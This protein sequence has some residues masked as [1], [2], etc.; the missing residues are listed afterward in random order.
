MNETDI[1]PFKKLSKCVK[2]TTTKYYQIYSTFYVKKKRTGKLKC[3]CSEVQCE[4]KK[5]FAT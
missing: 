1:E 3:K 5:A 4:I 2:Q